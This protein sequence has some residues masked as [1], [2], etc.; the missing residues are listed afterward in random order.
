MK[1]E[2]I[3]SEEILKVHFD[4]Y[5]A[6]RQL[7]DLLICNDISF[8]YLVERNFGDTDTHL[9]IYCAQEQLINI[10]SNAGVESVFEVVE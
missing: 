8:Q 5:D 1:L 6:Q 2:I 10:L 7:I 9:Y 3:P 4:D